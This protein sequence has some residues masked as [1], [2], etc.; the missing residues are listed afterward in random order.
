[1]FRLSV[2]RE[3]YSGRI[4]KRNF[5]D[6]GSFILWYMLIYFDFNIVLVAKSNI[7]TLP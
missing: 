2:Y 3:D 7:E 5:G 1:M 4:I 6:S